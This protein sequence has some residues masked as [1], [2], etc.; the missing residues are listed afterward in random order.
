MWPYD[1]FT[2]I[3]SGARLPRRGSELNDLLMHPR[4]SKVGVDFSQTVT[5]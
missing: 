4:W 3:Q 1:I 2:L 5:G